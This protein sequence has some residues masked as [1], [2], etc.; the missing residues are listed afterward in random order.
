MF[1]NLPS[2]RDGGRH[3][4]LKKATSAETIIYVR[5]RRAAAHSIMVNAFQ[6]ILLLSIVLTEKFTLP[7]TACRNSTGFDF[8]GTLKMVESGP[9]LRDHSVPTCL[10]CSKLDLHIP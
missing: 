3:T 9:R 7:Q 5:G 6:K 1:N 4:S 2:D 8:Y 10:N